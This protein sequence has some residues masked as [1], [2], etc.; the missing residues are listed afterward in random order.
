MTTHLGTL[1]FKLYYSLSLRLFCNT[2][3]FI[4]FRLQ[5]FPSRR[6][7]CRLKPSIA[8]IIIQMGA[9][10]VLYYQISLTSNSSSPNGRQY[11]RELLKPSCSGQALTPINN[12]TSVILSAVKHII[13][14]SILGKDST[15][16]RSKTSIWFSAS[17]R[18]GDEGEISGVGD[19]EV[20]CSK[21]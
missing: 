6:Y 17:S 8:I 2:A 21:C 15:L 7:R 11:A 20:G 3:F 19:G 18:C 1:P 4:R 5:Y 9:S 10:P 14:L 13:F 16:A 12:T